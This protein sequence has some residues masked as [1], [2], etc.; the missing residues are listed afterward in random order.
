M[1]IHKNPDI[2][3]SKL[4][5]IFKHIPECSGITENLTFKHDVTMSRPTAK[6]LTRL[7]K[8][9]SDRDVTLTFI[10]MC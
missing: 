1:G 6:H 3:L 8:F 2:N 9:K 7:N 4:K 5:V 10:K